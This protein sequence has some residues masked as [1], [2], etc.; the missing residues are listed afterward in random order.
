MQVVPAAL[1]HHVD[2]GAAFH[3]EFGRGKL[4]DHKLLSRVDRDQRRRNAHHPGLV[5]DR[6]TVEAVVVRNAIHQEVVG[7]A[8]RAVDVDGQEPAAGHALN[9]RNDS[10]QGID[11]ATADRQI[12]DAVLIDESIQ[13]VL[14]DF[15]ERGRC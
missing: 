8:P 6:I 11:V 13:A 1:H 2:H 10:Q 14:G 9:A 12:G 7:G 15:N 4:F 5:Q 3:P